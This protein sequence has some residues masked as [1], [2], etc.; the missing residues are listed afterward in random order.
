L[1]S[2]VCP[3]RLRARSLCVRRLRTWRL[4]ARSF[5]YHRRSQKREDREAG[6]SRG[7]GRFHPGAL[8]YRSLTENCGAI[9]H[10]TTRKGEGK[11]CVEKRLLDLQTSG[12]YESRVATADSAVEARS[13]S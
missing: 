1:P 9:I 3:R 12:W 4:G 5:R 10:T 6:E 13:S 7:A 8:L 11:A 2:V